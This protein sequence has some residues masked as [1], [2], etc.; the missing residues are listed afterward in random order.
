[1]ILGI[2]QFLLCI[3]QDTHPFPTAPLL[4]GLMDIGDA[5]CHR[6]GV[7]PLITGNRQFTTLL[8][9]TVLSNEDIELLNRRIAFQLRHNETGGLSVA[10]LGI[11]VIERRQIVQLVTHD[12]QQ[13][14][15]E[16]V[17]VRAFLDEGLISILLHLSQLGTELWRK[18]R[19]LGMHLEIA[20]VV[21]HTIEHRLIHQT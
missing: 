12:T 8:Q 7:H 1:M 13:V 9:V 21:D 17:T 18:L 19:L 2:G 15:I 4:K 20:V 5:L 10:C 14:V 16:I 11:I 6:E 3:P